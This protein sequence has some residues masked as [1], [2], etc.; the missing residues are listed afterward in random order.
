MLDKFKYVRYID[1]KNHQKLP[2]SGSD[3]VKV[4]SEADTDNHATDELFVIFL[5]Y[6]WIG[7]D[8]PDDSKNTQWKRMVS[9]AE[10]FLA[11]NPNVRL[12]TLGIWLVSG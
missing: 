8:V 11:Q 5:S 6:R 9:C 1:F 4:Y 12:E 7:G 10:A 3:L 2:R